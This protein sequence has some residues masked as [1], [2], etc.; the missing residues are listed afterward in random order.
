MARNFR[1]LLVS[2]LA[3]WH[4]RSQK[5]ISA[6][7]GIPQKRVSEILRAEGMDDE[8]LERLLAAVGASPAEVSIVTAC[9]ES[10]S[11]LEKNGDLTAK[12]RAEV[13]RSV[14]ELMGRNRRALTEAMLR[15]RTA[16][17]LDRYPLPDD[18]EPARWH[19]TMLLGLLRR[20]PEDE[21]WALVT[22]AEEHR[23]WALVE[24]LCGE[25]VVQTSRDLGRAA[26]LARLAR[27]AARRV[28]GPKSWRRRVRTFAAAHSA[29]VLRV[30]GSL[31]AA[32]AL[33]R[34]ARRLWEAGS[35]PDGVLDPGRLLDLE[36]S[37]RRDQ[38][39]FE[40]ALALLEQAE[41]EP[42]SGAHP[43]QQGFHAG[44]DER[45]RAGYRNSRRS[46]GLRYLFR[47]R[48]DQGLPFE[49]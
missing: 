6:A 19:A 39:R 21:Q 22:V 42:L 28:L 32:D 29:N 5:Q 12:E 35:D 20:L 44:S 33:F 27:K 17:A 7:S 13:E 23:S 3:L 48:H 37:L 47:A 46:G 15:S 9:L 1:S 14:Q 40:E 16:P 24:R 4:G 36:A 26:F 45:I 18:R 8:V 34:R 43:D 49:R 30:A 38:R 25:S 41:G 11:F 10:L 31:K 2:I